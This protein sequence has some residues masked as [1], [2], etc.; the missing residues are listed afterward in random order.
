MN[1]VEAVKSLETLKKIEQAL[2]E[3]VGNIYADIWILGV[4]SGLRSSE[5]LAITFEDIS[6]HTLTIINGSTGKERKVWLDSTVL[7]VVTKRREANPEHKYL[8]QSDSNRSKALEKP[9]SR[10]AVSKAFKAVG[11]RNSIKLK[12][13]MHSMRRTK[14]H[15]MVKSGQSLEAIANTF[16][17]NRRLM[18]EMYIRGLNSKNLDL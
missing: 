8:F 11:E 4:H 13:G 7:D 9:I 2:R 6:D 14:Y 15:Q 17:H 18:T 10:E 12:L 3:N 5:L 16:G 1:E